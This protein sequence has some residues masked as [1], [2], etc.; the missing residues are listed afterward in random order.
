MTSDAHQQVRPRRSALYLPASNARALEKARSLPCDVV[1]LDLEDAVAPEAKAEARAAAVAA[2][3]AGGFGPRELI[4]RVNGL[5]TPWGA[6]DIAAVGAAGPDAVLAPKVG[7]AED[8]ATF[9]AALADAPAHTR[10]WAMIET[11][12]AV[13]HLWQIAGMASASRLSGQ[14]VGLNDLAKSMRA[15]LT[16]DRAGFVAILAQAVAAA[17]GHGLTILDAV[18][19]EIQDVAALEAACRQGADLGF[20]GKSL[21]HPAQIE[22]AN[23]AFAPSDDEL[24]WSRAV[25]A[26]FA[27]PANAGV[28]VLKVEG[29][30]AE[31]LHLVEAERLVALDAAIALKAAA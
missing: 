23:R 3:R 24:A 15:R 6:E 16:P 1:I 31:L 22:I 13:F 12:S 20:D 27:D 25:I 9:D 5:D 28:G 14:I 4:V 18:S 21:I 7:S 26:A 10:L 17:R 19:N 2:I 29:R 11:P 8:V 30:M